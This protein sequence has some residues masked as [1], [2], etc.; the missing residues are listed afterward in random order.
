MK[1]VNVTDFGIKEINYYWERR[2]NF[3]LSEKEL[4]KVDATGNFT[5]VDYRLIPEPLE[6]NKHFEHRT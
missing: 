3:S 2:K 5:M 1:L 4:V 6:A